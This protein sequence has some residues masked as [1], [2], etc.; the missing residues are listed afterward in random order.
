MMT[1]IKAAAFTLITLVTIA[2]SNLPYRIDVDQGNLIDQQALSQLSIG[3]SKSEV[4]Q[5][6]GSSLLTDMFHRDRWDYVQYYQQGS[7]QSVKES[8]VSLFFVNGLLSRINNERMATIETAPL[9]YS[10]TTP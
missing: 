2:C 4:Q 9:P 10:V 5:V 3:M 6:L 7:T 1:T 8:Q